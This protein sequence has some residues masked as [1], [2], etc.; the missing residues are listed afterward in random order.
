[1]ITTGIRVLHNIERDMRRESLTVQKAMSFAVSR[2]AYTASSEL[3]KQL[4]LGRLGLQEKQ[5]LKAR[6][7]KRLRSRKAD[8]RP[9]VNLYK[10]VIYRKGGFG[11][12]AGFLRVTG[13]SMSAEYGFLGGSAQ[14]DWY[15][16][17][18]LKH[19]AG[20][21]IPL[22][23]PELRAKKAEMGIHLKK[24]TTY[25]RVPARDPV[26]A[27]HRRNA[28]RLGRMIGDIFAA[29]MRGERV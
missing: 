5:P 4:K 14:M 17:R 13:K 26:G 10:G 11:S 24:G 12:G 6:G 8:R 23:D 27:Y 29:K 25:A 1:M 21:R 7:G 19:L 20:Y 16:E 3:T 18:A 15:R 2:A 22:T 9:L 28:G